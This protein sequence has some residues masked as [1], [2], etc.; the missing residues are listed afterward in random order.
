MMTSL[1]NILPRIVTEFIFSSD[2]LYSLSS[3][4]ASKCPTSWA[5]YTSE[6]PL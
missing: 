5:P 3:F 2:K 6:M 4:Q 1:F